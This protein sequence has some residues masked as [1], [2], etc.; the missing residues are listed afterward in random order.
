MREAI[1]DDRRLL[2]PLRERADVVIDTTDLTHGA[3]KDRVASA[4]LGDRPVPLSVTVVAFGFKF[5]VPVDIDMLFDVRFLRNPNYDPEL[6]PKTGEDADVAR[7]IEGDPS[8]APFL[9]RVSGLIEFLIPQ[10]LAEGKSHLTIGIGCTGGRH[11]SVYVARALAQRLAA[12][13]RLAITTEARD[14]AEAI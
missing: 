11:R 3:L 14:I 9:D 6:A 12:D 5:G 1:A 4:C 10:Y 2:A 8:L 7:F 13:S